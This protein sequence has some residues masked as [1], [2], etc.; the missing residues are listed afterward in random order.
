MRS[1]R[2]EEGKRSRGP[3]VATDGKEV[4][5]SNP[6]EAEEEAK[7]SPKVERARREEERHCI[8][9]HRMVEKVVMHG[10]TRIRG[11]VANAAGCMFARFVL[12]NTRPTPAREEEIARIRQGLEQ[13]Q[14]DK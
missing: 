4:R 5:A 10:T 11:A 13:P 7:A 9:R 3:H 12:A 8:A 14:K 2:W 1:Q 6:V